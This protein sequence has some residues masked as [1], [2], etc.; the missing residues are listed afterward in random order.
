MSASEISVSI[1]ARQRTGGVPDRGAHPGMS[2]VVMRE[3]DHDKVLAIRG[4]G[5]Q[6]S[7]LKHDILCDNTGPVVDSGQRRV[8][9]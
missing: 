3:L 9:D 5:Q 8:W 2:T 6:D 4:C 7:R 1:P